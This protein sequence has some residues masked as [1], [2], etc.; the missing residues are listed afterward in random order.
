MNDT[1]QSV[2]V[3]SLVVLLDGSKQPIGTAGMESDQDM[4]CLRSRLL[5]HLNRHEAMEAF[6]K[7][8]MG[9]LG[10]VD[11]DSDSD[12]ESGS[13]SGSESDS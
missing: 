6:T 8:L 13:E 11:A 4:A 3:V 5:L 12:S 1:H 7:S 9:L 10:V 2:V